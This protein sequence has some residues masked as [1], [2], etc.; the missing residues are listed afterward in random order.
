MAFNE[1]AGLPKEHVSGVTPILNTSNAPGP[2]FTW[3]ADGSLH[4]APHVVDALRWEGVEVFDGLTSVTFCF[5]MKIDLFASAS[6]PNFAFPNSNNPMMFGKEYT[7]AY[8]AGEASQSSFGFFLNHDDEAETTNGA[9]TG[10]PFPHLGKGSG[11]RWGFWSLSGKGEGPGGPGPSGFPTSEGID[12]FYVW[13]GTWL[14]W[15]TTFRQML[16]IYDVDAPP[17]ER[18]KLWINGRREFP[19]DVF[20]DVPQPLPATV[21]PVV[22][23]AINVAPYPLGG[24]MLGSWQ[25]LYVWEGARPEVAEALLDDPYAMYRATY[26]LEPEA[27]I[28]GM[29]GQDVGLIRGLGMM[30]E[31]GN[32]GYE[33]HD[34]AL[35]GPAGANPGLIFRSSDESL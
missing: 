9:H 1:G 4:L 33:G 26:V 12:T 27:G 13:R 11:G 16:F 23:G 35:L 32:F 18:W 15:D 17:A 24:Q 19:A 30:V 25:Y 2:N 20:I 29:A 14:P 10:I 34:V 7:S 28:F 22:F 31:A 3:E 8:F 6:G 5:N 21:A